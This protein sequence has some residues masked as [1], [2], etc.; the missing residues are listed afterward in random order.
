MHVS[1][2]AQIMCQSIILGHKFCTFIKSGSS[3]LV[4]SVGIKSGSSK[5]VLSVWI[6]SGSSKLVSERCPR[7]NRLTI[8]WGFMVAPNLS[9]G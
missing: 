8:I 4:L 9:V 2:Q 3:K 1:E 7:A 5:L 6:K